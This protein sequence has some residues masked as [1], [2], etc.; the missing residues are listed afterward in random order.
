MIKVM[1]NKMVSRTTIELS[2]EIL[3]RAEPL[4][5]GVS[6]NAQIFVKT[7]ECTKDQLKKIETAETPQLFL[8]LMAMTFG[9]HL[10]EIHDQFQI[11]G[12]L[13]M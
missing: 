13:S 11:W 12:C 7:P 6:S 8:I 2:F 10:Q 3:P 4:S 9:I 1:G 5:R